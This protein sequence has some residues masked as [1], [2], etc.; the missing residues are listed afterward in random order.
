M[1]RKARGKPRDLFAAVPERIPMANAIA[2][3]ARDGPEME[4]E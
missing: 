4:K 3:A 2:G 1:I